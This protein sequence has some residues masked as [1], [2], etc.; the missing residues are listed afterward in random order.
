MYIN[1]STDTI[2]LIVIS[3]YIITDDRLNVITDYIYLITV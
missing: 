3:G 1:I 2:Y